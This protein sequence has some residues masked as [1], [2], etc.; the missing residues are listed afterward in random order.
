MYTVK[1]QDHTFLN[2][3]HCRPVK[4]P[5]EPPHWNPVSTFDHDELALHCHRYEHQ[6]EVIYVLCEHL[7]C[8]AWYLWKKG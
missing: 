8:L 7:L 3:P 1:K 6:M 4:V 2:H 5:Y